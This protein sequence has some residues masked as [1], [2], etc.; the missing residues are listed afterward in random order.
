MSLLI[1]LRRLLH[2][3]LELFDAS[4]DPWMTECVLRRHPPIRFPLKTVVNEI[5][6]V[7][8]IIVRLHQLVQL[9]RINGTDLALRVRLLQRSVVIVEKDLATGGHDYH[10]ARRHSLHL[11]Y[12]LH[13]LL[14]ILTG[15]DGEANEE[16]VED[17]AER[18]HVDRWR[19][20]DAHHDF[21][22][23][24]EPRLNVRIELVL[25]VGAR[26][27]IYDLDAT[28]IALA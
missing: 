22:R 23:P 24:I 9:L 10:G 3:L 5:N 7:A 20:A 27:K 18:P 1:L 13:L 19:V 15:E 28:F 4:L 12:A 2:L 26:A 21:R 25:L 14:L 16:F 8:L 17:A 11:H 6:E